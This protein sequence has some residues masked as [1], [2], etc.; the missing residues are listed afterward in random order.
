MM[1]S[2][3][4]TTKRRRGLSNLNDAGKYIILMI[5]AIIFIGPFYWLFSTAL[6]TIPDLAAFPPQFWPA[7]LDWG[8]FIGALTITNFAAY[9]ANSCILAVTYSTLVTLSSALVGFGFARLKGK[10]KRTLFLIMLSTL[11]L[12]QIITTIPT[13]VLFA[14][15]GLI[16][17][18]WPWVLW[19][20]GSSPF[21]SFLFRQFFS[22]IPVELEEAAIID[23]CGYGRI[24]WRIFLPLSI[25][26]IVTSFIISFTGVWGD[27]ITPDLFLSQQNTTLAVAMT[28]GYTDPHGN[29]LINVIAAGSIFYILPVLII[30]FFAQRSFVNG[31]VT[32]G[33]KG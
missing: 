23:G 30:F 33:L 19:G 5:L 26:V 27:Y 29:P 24:F 21:L 16:D 6:K 20:L 7:H 10:G 17:T 13:Y 14:R 1:Q 15:L 4:P 9:A 25:P 28:V 22:A 8:N 12:P 31:I 3:I 2:S 11:M 18:Y 32:T